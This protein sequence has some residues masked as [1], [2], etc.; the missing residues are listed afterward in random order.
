MTSYNVI[1]DPLDLRGCGGRG[2]EGETTLC[3]WFYKMQIFTHYCE[4]RRDT[5]VI[6]EATDELTCLSV[7]LHFV[8]FTYNWTVCRLKWEC[9]DAV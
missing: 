4:S 2:G 9:T 5:T 3:F 7:F 8:K 1:D 6:S